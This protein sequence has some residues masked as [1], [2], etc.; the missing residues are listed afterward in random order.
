MKIKSIV[1]DDDKIC[2]STY[3]IE[4]SKYGHCD[5]VNSGSSAINAYKESIENNEPYKL[6]L[7]DVIM[8]EM[9]GGQVLNKIREL[10]KEKNIPEIDKLRVIVVSAHDDWYNRNI[11]MKKLN[12]SFESFLIKSPDFDELIDKILDLGFV[13]D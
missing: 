7:L 10:E 1:V 13:L 5:A 8:P 6:M 3:K 11:I 4:M 2:A 9:D 12:P